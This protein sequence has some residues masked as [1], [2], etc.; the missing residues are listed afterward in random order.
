MGLIPTE[1]LDAIR[2]KID[3]VALVG[4]RV[5]LV[6]SGKSSKGCCPF[7]KES[8]PSFSVNDERKTFH[9]FGCG[10]SGDVFAFVMKAENISFVEAIEKLADRAG[11]VIPA[12]RVANPLDAERLRIKEVLEFAATHYASLLKKDPSAEGARQYI[13]SRHLNAA[14]VEEF[15][16][17]YSP[18]QDN[19]TPIALKKGYD[20]GILLKAG[21]AARRSDGRLRDYFFGRLMFPI[22]DVKG[23]VIGLG[24]RTMDDSG[25]KY[26]NSPES[27][28]FSKGRV[29]YGLYEGV[30]DVRK[31]RRACLMEG[32]MDVISA[33][34]H[35]LKTACATLGTA[36]TPEHVELI[37]RYVDKAVIVFDAD[38]AGQSAAVRGAEAALAGG[39]DVRVA[40]VSQGKDPDEFLHA[41]GCEA[42]KALLDASVD[43][44]AFK[45]ELLIKRGG[46]LTSESKSAIAKDVLRSIAQCPDE[47]LKDEW[48][49]RLAVRLGV[50]EEALRRTGGKAIPQSGRVV[51]ATA[52][53]PKAP[54]RPRPN[55][56]SPQELQLLGVM[57]KAPTAA[58]AMEENFFDSASA[59][60]IFLKF[61]AAAPYDAGWPARLLEALPPWEA[62]AVSRLLADEL[63][64]GDPSA[65][66]RT[67]ISKRMRK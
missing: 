62:A 33:H 14:S 12:A 5:Q 44:V 34:Q 46:Q 65:V 24:G 4:E 15:Q 49:R 32:Y 6:R 26:L 38:N 61:R 42:F 30:A 11:V 48:V 67:M 3:I 16:L 10:E 40:S 53:R 1:T 43:L 19:F 56:M 8:T 55:E 13:V 2:Q 20:E 54:P 25:P 35:G 23:A 57:V 37:K 50:N 39:L 17:G 21:L 58:A 7:H 52:A 22:K 18:R 28:V 27:S 47:I 60:L 64:Y 41:N 51:V 29:L 45:T 63:R 36:L 66:L 31:E 9:C 59:R